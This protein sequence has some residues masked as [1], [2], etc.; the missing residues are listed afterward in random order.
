MNIYFILWVII[1]Y[2]GTYFVAQ[3]AMAL[4]IGSSFHWLLCLIDMPP[5]LWGLFL[6]LR[7]YLLSGIKNV[8][9]TYI[10]YILCLSP[11][12]SHFPKDPWL[13]LLKGRAARNS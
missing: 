7:I 6:H 13:L 1:Q 5:S 10:L 2:Y 12:I 8:A 3:S 9:G 4:A 11:T